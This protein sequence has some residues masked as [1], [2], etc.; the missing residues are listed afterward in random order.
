MTMRHQHAPDGAGDGI[1]TEER[2]VGK[3]GQ[4]EGELLAVPRKR[5]ADGG[6]ML[7]IERQYSLQLW[8]LQSGLVELCCSSAP[9][10]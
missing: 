2:L 8:G 1:E 4:L 10:T 5:A 9:L 7:R 3:T 6:E